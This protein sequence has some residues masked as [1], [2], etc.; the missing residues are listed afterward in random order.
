MWIYAT[1]PVFAY[2]GAP[3]TFA[4]REMFDRTAN[5]LKT[6]VERTYVLG[7]S[8]CC[9]P[10]IPVSVGGDITGQPLSAF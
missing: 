9:L 4:F 2:R 7:Y 5:T 6:I 10:A 1:G 8:C 3:E